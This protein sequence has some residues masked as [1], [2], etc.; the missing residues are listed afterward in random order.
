MLTNQSNKFHFSPFPVFQT[1]RLVLRKM[2]LQDSKEIFLLRSDKINRQFVD[3]PLA[4]NIE[5]AQAFIQ[6][7]NLAK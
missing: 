5:E 7:I 2:T 6:K 1:E 4:K 3:S